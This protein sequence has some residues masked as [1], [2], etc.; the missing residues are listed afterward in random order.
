MKNNIL[1]V[2]LLLSIMAKAQQISFQKN[3]A[4]GDHSYISALTE[5]KNADMILAYSS[6]IIDTSHL[7]PHTISQH[8]MK[9]DKNGNE[10]WDKAL[11]ADTTRFEQDRFTTQ[12]IDELP[13]GSLLLDITHP[14]G[15]KYIARFDANGNQQ[16][17]TYIHNS[18]GDLNIYSQLLKQH[19]RNLAVS[20]GTAIVVGQSFMAG[21][22]KATLTFLNKG[23]DSHYDRYY[24][25]GYFNDAYYLNFEH[26]YTVGVEQNGITETLNF[27]DL[28]TDGS[29]NYQIRNT[30][31]IGEKIITT[32]FSY[33]YDKIRVAESISRKDTAFWV[34]L[35][36]YNHQGQLLST[37]THKLSCAAVYLNLSGSEIDWV[38]SSQ[39]KAESSQTIEKM[40]SNKVLAFTFTDSFDNVTVL[41]KLQDENYIFAFSKGSGI[42]IWKLNSRGTL[43]TGVTTEGLFFPNPTKSNLGF[44]GNS[45]THNH[46]LAIK[47]FDM[48]GN[49]IRTYSFAAME[50]VVLN[51]SNIREGIYIYNVL[52]DLGAELKG[53]IVIAQ[54]Y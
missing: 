54:K 33:T 19:G 38:L 14:Y 10:L 42:N 44:I 9:I 13:D 16:W 41:K 24:Y 52:T 31:K 15:E 25:N 4:K 3:Y 43:Q 21:I 5:L 1:V 45:D 22:S 30:H 29:T 40:R 23:G 53:K 26:I 50:E 6:I 2:F 27:S 28:K 35:Y 18:F 47:L 17:Q 51:V 39:C 46:S 48:T 11:I 7:G 12:Y 49:L 20:D 8:L 32:A 37:T 36:E 34:N